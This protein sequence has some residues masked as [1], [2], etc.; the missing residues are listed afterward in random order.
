MA[1]VPE[2]SIIIPVRNE[3]QTIASVLR[4]LA[5]QDRISD[6]QVVVVDGGSTDDTA[7]V[8]D[9]F[10]FVEVL[11]SGAGLSRQMNHGAAKAEG[12]ALWFLHADATLPGNS[13]ISHILAAL[14]D[15]DV[16][17][18]ACKFRIRADDIYYRF[19]NTAVNLRAKWLRRPYG[20]QGIFVRRTIF[21]QAGGFHDMPCSDL[22]LFL[23]IRSYG[24]TRM[25]KAVVA[26]SARTWHRYGKATT[27]AWHLREWL[28]YEWTRKTGQISTEAIRSGTDSSA[29][30]R[31]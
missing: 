31:A 7:S 12:K 26:T 25:I 11:T 13:T 21:Y 28:G 30:H 4:S 23:R 3:Q 8:A 22:D 1:R 20:D 24:E 16:V 2:L 15:P 19:V 6:C 5:R 14:A 17:G 10:P 29:K 9:A 18:G 27:T